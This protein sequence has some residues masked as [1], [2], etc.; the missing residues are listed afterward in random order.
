MRNSS[1]FYESVDSNWKDTNIRFL[2]SFVSKMRE[3]AI[4]IVSFI[5]L[6]IVSV[7]PCFASDIPI[8]KKQI[9]LSFAP[10]VKQTGPAVVNIFAKTETQNQN[11]S[12]LF[13]DPFF[14]TIFW[15]YFFWSTASSKSTISWFRCHSR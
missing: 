1:Y 8:T 7:S 13:V 15:R 3:N 14:S 10:L 9:Q 6:T 11:I 4:R 2:G 12:P 5:F